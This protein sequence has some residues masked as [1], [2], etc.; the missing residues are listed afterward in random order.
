M[1]ADAGHGNATTPAAT[2]GSCDRL[3]NEKSMQRQAMALLWRSLKGT[4]SDCGRVT[5]FPD[6]SDNSPNEEN[7]IGGVRNLTRGRLI[8]WWVVASS[9]EET[10]LD[11]SCKL[12]VNENNYRYLPV[13]VCVYVASHKVVLGDDIH[14]SY[15][16]K[17]TAVVCIL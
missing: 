2:S 11:I 10:T 13:Y 3:K 8:R 9:W 15:I 6:A 16:V 5:R 7:N 12:D 4:N 1:P 17:H 14:C